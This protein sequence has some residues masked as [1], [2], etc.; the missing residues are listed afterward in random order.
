MEESI[1]IKQHKKFLEEL[2]KL[3]FVIISN[4]DDLNNPLNY[5]V[6]S[7]NVGGFRKF[8]LL[9]AIFFVRYVKNLEINYIDCLNVKFLSSREAYKILNL[10]EKYKFTEEKQ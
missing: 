6:C 9:D 5:C 2:K 10:I 1:P 7:K 3:S 8:F 4:C